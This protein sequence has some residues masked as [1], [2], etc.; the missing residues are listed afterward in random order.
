[1]NNRTTYTWDYS[2]KALQLIDST[3]ISPN[4][5]FELRMSY[6]TFFKIIFLMVFA[7]ILLGGDRS[8]EFGRG[9]PNQVSNAQ[10][11]MP[12]AVPALMGNKFSEEEVKEKHWSDALAI[13]V[14]DA[15]AP[16]KETS[17]IQAADKEELFLNPLEIYQEDKVAA[18]SKKVKKKRKDCH[19]YIKRFKGVAVSEMKK[20]GIP[21]SITLA[22]GILESNAGTSRLADENRNHFGIKC[23]SSKCQ[24]GHCSNY[25]DDDHK[26]FFRKFETDWESY[27]AHSLLLAKSKRY[28]KLYKLEKTDYKGWAMGLQ[29]AGYATGSQY[30]KKLIKLIETLDLDQYDK[31]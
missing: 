17:V 15:P 23:F 3:V 19:A 18:P 28:R 26:D 8:I 31:L 5:N 29:E 16:A 4:N 25:H 20:Y 22:Q 13:S 27:R 1:M 9:Q 6:N 14:K 7:Y 30:G 12:P 24:K 10:K 21:A 2:Q 11:Y